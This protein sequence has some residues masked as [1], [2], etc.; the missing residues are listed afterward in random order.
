MLAKPHNE[1]KWENG[2]A[3]KTSHRPKLASPDSKLTYFSI[4]RTG[5]ALAKKT[6]GFPLPPGTFHDG[7]SPPPLPPPCQTW[8]D[9]QEETLADIWQGCG[10]S[11]HVPWTSSDAIATEAWCGNTSNTT[12]NHHWKWCEALSLVLRVCS[13][14]DNL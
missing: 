11:M 2:Y 14:R 7:H 4:G 8:H 3:Q 5:P 6:F 9:P 1:S 10:A 13:L 12:G